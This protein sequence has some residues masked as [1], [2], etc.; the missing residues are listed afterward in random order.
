VAVTD[1]CVGGERGSHGGGGM[2]YS[3]WM[4]TLSPYRVVETGNFWTLKFS[5]TNYHV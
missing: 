4:S 5:T 1:L 2:V 3:V